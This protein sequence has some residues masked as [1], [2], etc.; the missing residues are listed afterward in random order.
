M[1]RVICWLP[2]ENMRF[3][4]F[5]NVLHFCWLTSNF[6]LLFAHF[7]SKITDPIIFGAGRSIYLILAAFVYSPCCWICLF[8]TFQSNRN[9][10]FFKRHE[11]F[12][13]NHLN[14]K[15]SGLKILKQIRIDFGVF[16]TKWGR[17][18]VCVCVFAVHPCCC[19]SPT[20]KVEN[21]IERKIFVRKRM[22]SNNILG[23]QKLIRRNEWVTRTESEQRIEITYKTANREKKIG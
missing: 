1:F 18:V 9:L 16:V 7:R 20:T 6:G 17:L 10:W 8:R 12:N 3:F 21:I 13:D 14:V 11:T 15:Q 4:V 19:T 5:P 2:T 22:P 23:E